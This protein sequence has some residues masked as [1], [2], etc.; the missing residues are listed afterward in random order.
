M[1]CGDEVARGSGWLSDPE[2][3]DP[4]GIGLFET[5]R[6]IRIIVDGS[7]GM[8]HQ[9]QADLVGDRGII[10]VVD[11]GFEFEF[12]SLDASSEFGLMARRHLPVNYPI[13]NP[14]MNALDDLIRCVESGGQPLS[15]GYDGRRAFEMIA[16]VC[17]SH[18]EHRAF[19]SFP[20]A[21]RDLAIESN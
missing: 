3:F 12:W 17:Q 15:S 6:G 13:R 2:S 10:R 4:G 16:A 9:Y 21:R 1:L 7:A 18:R 20:L 8:K 19:V 14:M 11:G 5:R